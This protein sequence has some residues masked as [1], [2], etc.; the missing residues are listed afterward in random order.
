MKTKASDL[1]EELSVADLVFI[2]T[3]KACDPYLQEDIRL[4]AQ[5]SLKLQQSRILPS[6]V[7][8]LT[9]KSA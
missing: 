9:S 5:A 6:N 3:Y 7:I 8:R 2:A 1:L 4:F